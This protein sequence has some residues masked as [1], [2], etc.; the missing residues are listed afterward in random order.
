MSSRTP[1]YKSK[2]FVPIERIVERA[3]SAYR[4]R[5]VV[6]GSREGFRST[7]LFL[8]SGV[9]SYVLKVYRKSEVQVDR[10]RKGIEISRLLAR[11]GVP[12]VP[13]IDPI[14]HRGGLTEVD[15][16]LLLLSRKAEGRPYR[17]GAIAETREAAV[18]LARIH[19][20]PVEMSDPFPGRSVAERVDGLK[21]EMG[22]LGSSD[23][24]PQLS[25]LLGQAESILGE[26]EPFEADAGCLTHGDYRGQNLLFQGAKVVA[27]LDLDEA[28]TSSR[29]YDL[30][31]AVAFFPAVL[32]DRPFSEEETAA[33][34]GAYHKHRPLDERDL[35]TMC[36]LL[37]VAVI[38]GLILWGQIR[39]EVGTAGSDHPVDRWIA[40]Y[41]ELLAWSRSDASRKLLRRATIG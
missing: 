23:L 22:R 19:A 36:D 12:A 16:H 24:A 6:S 40:N 20:T 9:E 29:L 35:D 7:V 18:T 13:P 31:Y 41:L 39:I 37:P 8:D 21:A 33:F 2:L 11:Q 15:G 17:I 25:I 27:V 10:I 4:R 14:Q 32:S 3:E 34:L 5:F 28:G 26:G 1:N 30:C 38:S